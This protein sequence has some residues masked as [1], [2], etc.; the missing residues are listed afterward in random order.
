M[1]RTPR[2][3][4]WSKAAKKCNGR[5]WY[6]GVLPEPGDITVDHA[7]PRSR[8]GQNAED[9]L[10]PACEYCNNEKGNLTV[11]EYKKFCKVKFIRKLMSMGFLCRDLSNIKIVF[12]GEGND[13][14]FVIS[15]F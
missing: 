14:P 7:K 6:C 15:D 12:F 8:G 13:S 2:K 3:G 11:R 5:C 4:Q 1:P 9:N 10:L